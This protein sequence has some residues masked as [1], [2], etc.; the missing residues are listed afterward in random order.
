MIDI[1]D[2]LL[3]D[4]G[5][6]AEMSGVGGAIQL[7]A[8][9]ISPAFREAARHLPTFPFHLVLAGGED[10]ELAFTASPS[11]RKKI[12]ELIKTCGIE[13]APVGIVTP[14]PDVAVLNSDGTRYNLPTPGFNH[15]MF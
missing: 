9:P 5:H 8:L 15:F 7:D 3:A 1:S 14:L 12:T 2:G 4:F 6:I 11:H 13:A 10:Y